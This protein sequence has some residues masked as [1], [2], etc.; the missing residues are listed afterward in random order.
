VTGVQT[1]A[2]PIS[3]IPPSAIQ[4]PTCYRLSHILLSCTPCTHPVMVYFVSGQ[5]PGQP[6][7]MLDHLETRL[8]RTRT[9]APCPV[10]VMTK[11]GAGGLGRE[12][13]SA[14]RVPNQ[15]EARSTSA[16]ASSGR[17]RAQEPQSQTR[18]TLETGEG[19]RG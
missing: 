6:P 16:V 12:F 17:R 18:W 2:L 3:T 5:G 19:Q 4:A 11:C 1:C 9:V 14:R 15:D 8:W 13:T 7:K 10:P